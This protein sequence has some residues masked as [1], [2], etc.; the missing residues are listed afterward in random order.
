MGAEGATTRCVEQPKHEEVGRSIGPVPRAVLS[1]CNPGC[2]FW[3]DAVEAAKHT[4]A[5][6][7][8]SVRARTGSAALQRSPEAQPCPACRHCMSYS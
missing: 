3:G 2:S 4:L 5:L 7:N 8:R 6:F 1:P